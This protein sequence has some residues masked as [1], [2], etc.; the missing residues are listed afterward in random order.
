MLGGRPFQSFGFSERII[1]ALA[2]NDDV[3]VNDYVEFTKYDSEL[4]C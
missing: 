1:L 2:R 4:L 3:I